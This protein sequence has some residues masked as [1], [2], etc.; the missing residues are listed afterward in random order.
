MKI[1]N[2][3]GYKGNVHNSAYTVM[4]AIGCE[5]IISPQ[6]DYDSMNPESVV[7]IL[8]QQIVENNVDIIVG[9][10]LGGFYAA[11][12]SAQFNL[13]VILLNPC[14]MPFIYL[15]RL[16]Y[17]KDVKPYMTM[18]GKLL[19]LKKYNVSTVV[20]GQDEI[21]DTQELTKSILQNSRY[22]F[23][24][25]GKHSGATLPLKQC[26]EKFLS[27]IK[28]DLQDINLVESNDYKLLHQKW[29]NA[30]KEREAITEKWFSIWNH[31]EY[32]S[33]FDMEEFKT[34]F[35]ETWRYFMNHVGVIE[36]C[37][38]DMKILNYMNRFLVQ[39]NYMDNIANWEISTCYLFL[40]SLIETISSYDYTG[41]RGAFSEDGTV[42]LQL[43]HCAGTSSQ[44]EIKLGEFDR[45]YEEYCKDY[46]SEYEEDEFEEITSYRKISVDDQTEKH[47]MN[48]SV[49]SREEIETMISEGKFP[50]NTAVISFYDP[51]IKRIDKD[52]THVDYSGVC[53]H[54]FYSELDDLDLEVLK[55]KGYTYDTY[56]LE[57]DEIAEFVY[58]AYRSGMDIICQ[59]EYGQ[60]RSAGCAAAIMEHFNHTGISVFT[61]YKRYPNRVLY[62]KIFDAL[63]N[64]K[65][66]HQNMG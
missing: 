38:E 48:V 53:D 28:T 37:R 35:K 58:E 40:E 45:A 14:L 32:Y 8:R 47:P 54:V 25:K 36:I 21:I 5:N 29:R 55:E 39:L 44:S 20:G 2:I 30:E 1:L 15:P 23:I 43:P 31:I 59:C 17:I 56:F 19:K 46:K 11:I 26:F 27:Y 10:S 57:A 13:P 64:H 50:E 18:F 16:G 33:K 42:I 12:L 66:T 41:Y 22:I 63:E 7:A 4:E 60:S 61:D 62:H 6:L 51:A 34:L 24:P 9:T 3:H 49:Y 52:Y 65:K